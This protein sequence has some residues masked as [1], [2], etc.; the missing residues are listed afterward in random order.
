[1]TSAPG[2]FGR[3]S[4]ASGEGGDLG[5]GVYLRSALISSSCDCVRLSMMSLGRLLIGSP[6][7]CRTNG[8]LW[9]P[10]G[11]LEMVSVDR[12]ASSSPLGASDNV[13]VASFWGPGAGAGAVAGIG[14]PDG[15][16]LSSK[17]SGSVSGVDFDW[18]L[19][20]GARLGSGGGAGV[21]FELYC[22]P[23]GVGGIGTSGPVSLDV[24]ALRPLKSLD[25]GSEYL[26]ACQIASPPLWWIVSSRSTS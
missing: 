15:F 8:S 10:R 6:D 20:S 2:S 9:R 14:A 17:L 11:R 23:S 13:N 25:P 22:F 7:P 18:D 21:A 19:A 24:E 3:L 4:T 1:M 16:V 12:S 26:T 5:A